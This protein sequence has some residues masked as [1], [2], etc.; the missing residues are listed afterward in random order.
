MMYK[1]L[2]P[3]NR[4]SVFYF[5]NLLKT[6]IFNN[7]MFYLGLTLGCRNFP[8]RNSMRI[9]NG[10][11][12]V[13]YGYCK[14]RRG[15]YFQGP[16][17]YVIWFL[18]LIAVFAVPAFRSAQRS[19]NE[20][21]E[22]HREGELVIIESDDEIIFR[23]CGRELDSLDFGPGCELSTIAEA[24]KSMINEFHY[25]GKVRINCF[26]IGYDVPYEETFNVESLLI[27]SE[28]SLSDF[29]GCSEGY[30]SIAKDG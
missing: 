11:K 4:G 16:V 17:G 20:P 30:L 7:I 14:G 29:P 5:S 27:G 10:K 12:I 28:N 25:N 9:N 26:D 23:F 3:A 2:Q 18:I 6:L 24:A 1:N 21:V 13:R 8:R 19:S 15:L 22:V